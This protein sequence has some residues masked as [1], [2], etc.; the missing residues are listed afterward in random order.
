MITNS[1]SA[2]LVGRRAIYTKTSVDVT[3]LTMMTTALYAR[4]ST[5]EKQEAATQLQQLRRYAKRQGWKV[6]GE[7]VD[8]ESGAKAERPQFKRLFADASQGKFDVALFWSLDRFSREGV[9][10]TLQHLQRLTDYGCKW[11]ALTQEYLDSTGPFADA[12]VAIM[13]ALA[14]QERQIIRERVKAGLQ[15]ART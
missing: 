14:Q 7:Y 3:V 13:A 10:K 4:V 6:V 9:L 8:K 11:K 15:R 12:I 2:G 1:D 5:R